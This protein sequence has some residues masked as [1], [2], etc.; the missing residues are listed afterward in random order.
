MTPGSASSRSAR[1]ARAIVDHAWIVLAIWLVLAP[2]ALYFAL[3]VKSDNSPDRLI[4]EGDEDF[5]QTRVFQKIF[6]EGQYVVLLAEADDPFAPAVLKRVAAL[7]AALESVPKAKPLSALTIY[8]QTHPE[9]AATAADAAAFRAFATGTT[10]FRKQGLVG[11]G[12]LGIPMELQVSN[13]DELQVVL[14]AVDVAIA[15]FA[16]AP[17]PLTAVRKIGGPYVDRYLS[18]ETQRSTLL[19]MPLFG[20]FIVLLNLFLYRSFRTLFAFLL[21]IGV[22]VLFT[23]AFAGVMGFVSTIVSSLVPL[24]VL[25]TCTST[26]VYLHSL[27]VACPA[28]VDIREHHVF[29]L[30]NKFLPCTASIF[31]AAVGFA[32]LAVSGIRPIR[33]M[34]YW[35]AAGMVV[36]WF[37]SFTLFPALQRLLRTPP[38]SERR[39]AGAWWPRI[40]DRLPG[41]TYRFRWVLVPGSIALMFVGLGALLGV[42][43]L[44]EPMRLETDSLD[45]IDH[46][47]PLYVDTRR[48]EATMSG[49][50]VTEAWIHVPNGGVLDPG[51]LRGL[52]R[53]GAKL[54]ADGRVGS[55]LGP[56][57][58][59]QWVRYV[60]GQG[61]ALPDDPASWDKLAGDFEQ[62]VLSRPEFRGSIDVATLSNARIRVITRTGF[63]GY[64]G[65][66]SFLA[67]AWAEAQRHDP[68]LAPC[69]M[70]VV[71]E[72]VLQAKIAHYLVPTL[73]ESFA[74]TAAVIF[75]AFLVVFRSPAARLMA[76]IPS[77][78]AILVMFLVMR[79]TGIALNVATIL[80]ASTVLGA[81]E[82]DQ[83]HFFY[84]FQEG[85]RSGGTEAALRHALLVSGRAIIF[86]TFI[87]AGGFLALALSPLP[88]MRQ[89]GVVSA[90][91]FLLSMI[92]DFTALPASLWI[93]SGDAPGK[94]PAVGS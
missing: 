9:F 10:L 13:R 81:S 67:E 45:Y 64:A 24:T 58:L 11:D 50:T 22:T 36:T 2:V 76:M 88:P 32:A 87:N 48:F 4:V 66:K 12:V 54:E 41:F 42:W 94:D 92:A 90:C 40:V 77:V 80:I 21:T 68:A 31:A 29:T 57:T 3:S 8:R 5:Q 17:A 56:T 75:L 86:A 27:Y 93:V 25:I 79:L 38:S 78:F 1:L 73:T 49:L 6:P 65:L 34:G 71:G 63:D 20:L 16:A 62:L 39:T 82:N 74:I 23:E 83:I 84:H 46:R 61:D 47:L 26:L 37:A 59:L 60:Q 69:R 52:H 85:R 43:H 55:V 18:E 14:A 44:V 91:A 7:E 19:Y 28:G 33:E 70:T 30:C 89:F 53:F 51:V 35:V 15:P 72:G